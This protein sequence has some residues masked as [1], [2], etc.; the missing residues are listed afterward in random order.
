[1]AQTPQPIE[2]YLPLSTRRSVRVKRLETFLVRT[3]DETCYWWIKTVAPAA[4]VG[5]LMLAI[6]APHE[7]HNLLG[8]SLSWKMERNGTTSHWRIGI[9]QVTTCKIVHASRSR[10]FSKNAQK[11]VASL[12]GNFVSW[13]AL[14]FKPG[15]THSPG[16]KCPEWDR[17]VPL[18]FLLPVPLPCFVIAALAL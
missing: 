3:E 15:E 7:F 14:N 10:I 16:R 2:L 12:C 5:R 13:N 9:N 4:I 17:T 6:H 8:R 18:S 11:S 1:M